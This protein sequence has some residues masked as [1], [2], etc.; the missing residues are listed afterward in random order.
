MKMNPFSDLKEICAVDRTRE[1]QEAPLNSF[2]HF[3]YLFT[4]YA[5]VLAPDQ[6][7]ALA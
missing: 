6:K 3:K 4:C 1:W 5:G 7:S 2:I